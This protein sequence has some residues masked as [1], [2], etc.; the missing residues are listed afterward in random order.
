MK[1]LA[2]CPEAFV[3]NQPGDKAGGPS[4]ATT[5]VKGHQSKAPTKADTCHNLIGLSVYGQEMSVIPL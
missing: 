1:A 2:R 3:D 5:N 4:N